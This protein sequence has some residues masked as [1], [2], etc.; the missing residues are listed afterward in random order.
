MTISSIYILDSQGKKLILRDY[1]GD[2]DTKSAIATFVQEVVEAPDNADQ[3]PIFHKDDVHYAYI[4]HN[5]IYL[6]AVTRINADATTTISLLYQIVKVFAEYF[7]HVEEESIR[8]NFVMVYEL[9]DEMVDFGYPQ[10]TEPVILKEYIVQES[11]K[12]QGRQKAN[13]GLTN[14]IT[15]GRFN[16]TNRVTKTYPRNEIWLD[17]I[18]KVNVMISAKG[19]M[20]QHEV[21][22]QMRTKAH[23]NGIPVLFMAFNNKFNFSRETDENSRQISVGNVEGALTNEDFSFHACVDSS[24]IESERVIR[25]IPPDGEFNLLQYRLTSKL[26]PLIWVEPVVQRHD[27]SRI[28][29]LI[30]IKAQFKKSAHATDVSVTVPVPADASSPK[31]ACNHGTVKYTPEK[32]AFE[33]SIAQL[34]GGTEIL[35][36]AHFALPSISSSEDDT[37]E[38]SMKRPI[39]CHFSLP[40]HTVSGIAVR[41]INATSAQRSQGDYVMMPWIRY[42]T[43]A[44]EYQFRLS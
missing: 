2:V 3:K 5:N 9:L 29:Y 40:Q 10:N 15:G 25:F 22:G 27:R 20:L 13:A 35:V 38:K 11:Q 43:E 19:H 17:L 37:A 26:R 23:L 30:K 8:D 34:N 14:A 16:E 12:L 39:S 33:W 42:L 41:Y 21:M 18:E 28:E 32:D 44:G 24:K 36:R 7:D 31:L 1:R 6:V 4:K